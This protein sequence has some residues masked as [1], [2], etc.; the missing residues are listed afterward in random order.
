MKSKQQCQDQDE[1]QTFQHEHETLDDEE[2]KVGAG[3]A[4]EMR[5]KAIAKEIMGHNLKHARSN[6][7]E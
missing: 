2:V 1:G 4:T 6:S 7:D 5:S 3:L